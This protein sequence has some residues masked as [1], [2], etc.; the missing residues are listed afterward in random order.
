MQQI[1]VRFEHRLP[2][3]IAQWPLLELSLGCKEVQVSLKMLAIPRSNILSGRHR[4]F[5]LALLI[6]KVGSRGVGLG[7]VGCGVR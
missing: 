6:F 1:T 2:Q 4:I 7:G 3:H 5:F